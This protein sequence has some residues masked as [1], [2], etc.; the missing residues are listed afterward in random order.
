MTDQEQ[1]IPLMSRNV[2]G[3]V[4]LSQSIAAASGTVPKEYNLHV[5]SQLTSTVPYVPTNWGM[6]L[7]PGKTDRIQYSV[8][9]LRD[10]KSYMSRAVQA[11]QDGKVIFIAHLSFQT[12]EPKQPDFYIGAP[13]ATTRD[14]A[15]HSSRPGINGPTVTNAVMTPEE[16]TP[17]SE[18]FRVSLANRKAWGKWRDN[19]E[20]W[21]YEQEQSFPV[22][23]RYAVPS[24]YTERGSLTNNIRTAFWMRSREPFNGD[25][26]E[27]RAALAFQVEY[28]VADSQMSLGNI[29]AT[30][31]G[32]GPTM[33]ASLNHQ[34]WFFAPFN[35]REWVLLVV[36]TR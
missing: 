2:F 1:W 29:L 33:M 36:C 5:R 4:M 28:V 35:F 26:N 34:M 21:T 23:T 31:N 11:T 25:P 16:S 9:R 17:A 19:I 6:F 30:Q 15:W 7:L 20:R 13:V 3:G 22:E 10:G 14:L 12:E 32:V 8:T 27:Q 18:R 24:M